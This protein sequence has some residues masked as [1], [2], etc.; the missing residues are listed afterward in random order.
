MQLLRQGDGVRNDP[1][2]EFF[3]L[4]AETLFGAPGVIPDKD[5]LA[6]NIG[7]RNDGLR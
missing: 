6:K 1:E 7:G 3:V 5:A 4:P 2:H